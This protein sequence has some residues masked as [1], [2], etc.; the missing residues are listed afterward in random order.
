MSNRNIFIIS[1]MSFLT[2]SLYFVAYKDFLELSTDN[3]SI[4]I[5]KYEITDGFMKVK[6]VDRNINLRLNIIKIAEIVSEKE[7]NIETI[8]KDSFKLKFNEVENRIKFIEDLKEWNNY[9][10]KKIEFK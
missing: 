5:K 9:I 3:K 4:N 7:I 6:L 10:N 2:I 8:D 1:F